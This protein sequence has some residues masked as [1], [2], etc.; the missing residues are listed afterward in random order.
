MNINEKFV[1][2]KKYCPKCIYH[3]VPDKE[4]PCNECLTYPTNQGSEKPINFEE[5]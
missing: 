4:D 2:Y 1:D 3:D 5:D